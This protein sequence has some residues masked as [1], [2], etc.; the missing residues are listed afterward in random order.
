M[1]SGPGHYIPAIPVDEGISPTQVEVTH[2]AEKSS[3][4]D[5]LNIKVAARPKCITCHGDVTGPIS[6]GFWSLSSCSPSSDREARLIQKLPTI[7]DP[8]DGP[9]TLHALVLKE[10]TKQEARGPGKVVKLGKDWVN[11]FLIYPAEP[12]RNRL[13]II[14]P[15]EVLCM[16]RDERE[17]ITSPTEL[18]QS[19]WRQS[20]MWVDPSEGRSYKEIDHLDY[21]VLTEANPGVEERVLPD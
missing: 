14:H 1:R 5:Y 3:K 9:Y 15:L 19:T 10:L 4:E 17:S 18:M 21:Q 13:R 2:S 6:E 7:S 8:A 12:R 11:N 16:R 20:S